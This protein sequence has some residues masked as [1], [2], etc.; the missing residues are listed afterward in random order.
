MKEKIKNIKGNLLLISNDEE[1]MDA[2]SNNKNIDESYTLSSINNKEKSKNKLKLGNKKIQINK[3]KRYFNK[4]SIDYIVVDYK[5][6][7]DFLPRFVKNSIYL[8]RGNLYFY[9]LE[10]ENEIVKKYQR[11][12]AEIKENKE[13]IEINNKNTKNNIIKDNYYIFKDKKDK[14]LDKLS[15][16]L[17]SWGVICI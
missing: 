15:D 5:L 9:N 7:K 3:I 13:Y 14:I 2:A 12:K 17:T 1:L 6:I 4:K 11:Y 16:L 10:K 8:N